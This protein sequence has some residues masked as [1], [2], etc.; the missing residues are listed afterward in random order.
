MI[1][2][3]QIKLLVPQT[4]SFQTECL[5]SHSHAPVCSG[6]TVG[7]ILRSSSS[8]TCTPPQVPQI[9]DGTGSAG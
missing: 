1:L 7:M 9:W 8:V 5:L 3:Q 4:K 6:H 2:N